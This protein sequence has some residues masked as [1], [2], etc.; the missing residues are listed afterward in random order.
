MKPV[1]SASLVRTLR[2]LLGETD[3]AAAGGNE[4]ILARPVEAPLRPLRV[5][6]CDDNEINALLG[7][8]LLEKQGHSVAVAGD[9]RR[10]LALCE[11]RMAAGGS[12]DLILMDLHMPEM[13]GFEAARRIR[14][15]EPAGLRPTPIVALTADVMP[16]TRARCEGDLFDGWLAKPLQPDALRALAQRLSAD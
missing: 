4:P 6:L 3:F 15:M 14:A 5:L 9:G 10:A 16:E 2:T 13:D 7:R 12:F 1:R 11:E 8:G